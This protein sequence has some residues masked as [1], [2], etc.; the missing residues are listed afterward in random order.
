M[1][2]TASLYRSDSCAL[3]HLAVYRSKR[4]R[5]IVAQEG[6]IYVSAFALLLPHSVPGTAAARTDAAGPDTL[7]TSAGSAFIRWPNDSGFPRKA[8]KG[9]LPS[10]PYIDGIATLRYGSVRA[11]L[12]RAA[13]QY[14]LML[15]AAQLLGE[16]I[17][18]V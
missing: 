2:C 6:G 11:V 7:S 14:V 8:Q 5:K 1:F 16:V 9:L 3:G 10:P 15:R 17:R 18:V 13:M 12:P 4:E